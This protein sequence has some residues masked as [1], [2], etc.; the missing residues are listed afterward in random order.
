MLLPL[1]TIYHNVYYHALLNQHQKELVNVSQNG[2]KK[3]SIDLSPECI[4]EIAL[5][6]NVCKITGINF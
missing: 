3:I 2:K 6:P 5:Y 1:H 4:F